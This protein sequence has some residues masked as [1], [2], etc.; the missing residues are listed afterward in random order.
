MNSV[1][2]VAETNPHHEH[3]LTLLLRGAVFFVV[4]FQTSQSAGVVYKSAACEP[5]NQ[6]GS[7]G[8]LSGSV[9]SIVAA[10]VDKMIE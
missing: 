1:W 9:H 4:A 7:K 3:A 2:T 6:I 10:C 8:I 5:I